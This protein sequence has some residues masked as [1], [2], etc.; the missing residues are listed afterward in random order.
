MKAKIIEDMAATQNIITL[1]AGQPGKSG[2]GL[3]ANPNGGPV[4]STETSE[5]TEPSI[6]QR[7]ATEQVL[8]TET[9]EMIQKL[10]G[11]KI[12]AIVPVMPF[13]SNSPPVIMG[14]ESNGSVKVVED[15]FFKA[16]DIKLARGIFFQKSQTENFENVVVAGS[17][18]EREFQGKNPVGQTIYI[19]NQAFTVI[20]LLEKTKDYSTDNAYYIPYQ[21]ASKRFGKQKIESIEIYAKRVEDLNFL[22]KNIGYYLMKLTGASDPSEL[23]FNLA[24][25]RQFMDMIE[26]QTGTITMF[27]SGIAG[28]SLLVGGIGIMNIMLV[29]VTERTREIGIRKAIGAKRKDI[30]L[31]FLVESVI[32]SFIGGVIA[33]LVSYAISAGVHFFAPSL[34]MIIS[35]EMIFIATG[36]SV[37]MGVIFG[38]L[39]AWRAA[40][41]DAIEA[42]RFE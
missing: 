17:D 38:L 10:F 4:S 20:G 18:L 25:N 7:I 28:I 22:Q 23:N 11:D 24:T 36:F 12:K 26:K 41:M 6:A 16:R 35:I 9:I 30:V 27:I 13:R 29:S 19:N 31:Q 34:S 39:P 40:K 21:T 3:M 32:L 2:G 37:L 5:K 33:V 1:Q 42:L 8:S 15:A 14:K